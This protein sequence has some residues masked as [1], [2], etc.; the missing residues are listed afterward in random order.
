MQIRVLLALLLTCLAAPVQAGAV[1]GINISTGT[2]DGGPVEG[3]PIVG[4]SPGGPAERAGLRAGDVIVLVGDQSLTAASAAEASATLVNF[5]DTVAPDDRISVTYLRDGRAGTA[6]VVA[7]EIDPS[8]MQPGFPF[9]QSLEQLGDEIEAQVVRPFVR[10]WRGGVFRGMELVDLTPDLG[11]YFGTEQGIL[12]VRAPEGDG[13]PLRDG[14]VIVKIGGRTV[15]S[16]AHTM[17]ILR[18]YEPGEE[19]VFDIFRDQRRQ[20]LEVLMPAPAQ[21]G[22]GAPAITDGA[23]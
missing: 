6:T 17:R 18:S 14:D 19:L 7:A 5:M 12:V 11:R 13:I 3:V 15:Q 4:V 8:V 22:A 16:P 23:S 21:S 2:E 10:Q 20:T 1:L 9:R